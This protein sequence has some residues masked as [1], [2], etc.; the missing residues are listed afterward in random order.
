MTSLCAEY[1]YFARILP[2]TDLLF[3]PLTRI[4]LPADAGC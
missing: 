4:G 3:Q 1:S 2:C